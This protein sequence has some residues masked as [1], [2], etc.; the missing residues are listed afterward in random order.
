MRKH[1]QFN[2]RTLQTSLVTKPRVMSLKDTRNFLMFPLNTDLPFIHL[3]NIQGPA[4]FQ[5][6][7][8]KHRVKN[9]EEE[10]LTSQGQ[11]E[12]DE[13]LFKK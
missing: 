6:L 1:F 3:T 11:Q 7:S 8:E 4:M 9:F 5:I 10:I 13:R 2:H 12:K